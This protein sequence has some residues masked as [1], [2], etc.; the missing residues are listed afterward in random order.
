MSLA[1]LLMWMLW[2]RNQDMVEDMIGD[3]NYAAA[4]DKKP[5]YKI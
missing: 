5:Y 1:W 4:C 2:L 3:V